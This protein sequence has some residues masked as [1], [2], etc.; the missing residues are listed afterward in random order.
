MYRVI[1]SLI[2]SE[3]SL[4]R[5]SLPRVTAADSASRLA[6]SASIASCA[7]LG[8]EPSSCQLGVSA[9]N[10][11]R[12]SPASRCGSCHGCWT[13]TVLSS[14]PD[15]PVPS[16][17]QLPERR[18]PWL[19][20]HSR[21]CERV[22]GRDPSSGR[23]ARGVRAPFRAGSASARSSEDPS[24]AGD[25][26]VGLPEHQARGRRNEG[27][28]RLDSTVAVGRR[29]GR[30]SCGLFDGSLFQLPPTR[31]FADPSVDFDPKCLISLQ[32]DQRTAGWQAS[33]SANRGAG[34]GAAGGPEAEPDGPV[35]ASASGAGPIRSRRP[36]R[37]AGDVFPGKLERLCGPSAIAGG[38][39]S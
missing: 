24:G 10:V 18:Y 25:L 33:G 35:G 20:Y 6:L 14:A 31:C 7:L 21:A 22:A 5:T 30:S 3:N 16:G 36:G 32:V 13:A 19:Q 34:L 17:D 11:G 12:S 29:S 9:V 39:F 4:R 28:Q 37:S 2:R 8:C 38:S 15:R 23:S 1:R 27:G 26:E